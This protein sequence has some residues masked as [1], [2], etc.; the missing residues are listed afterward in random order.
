MFGSQERVSA[1]VVYHEES[2]HKAKLELISGTT[3]RE[4]DPPVHY[5]FFRQV[6]YVHTTS[7]LYIFALKNQCIQSCINQSYVWVE[8]YASVI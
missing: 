8:N 1:G 2:R 3:L 5:N 4:E 7:K 6:K